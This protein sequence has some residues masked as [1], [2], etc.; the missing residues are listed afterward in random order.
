MHDLIEGS[1]TASSDGSDRE[2]RDHA[3]LVRR[4]VT[5]IRNWTIRQ[6]T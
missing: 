5:V 1:S 3:G 6:I 2:M 4:I